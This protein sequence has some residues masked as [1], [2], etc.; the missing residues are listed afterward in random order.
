VVKTVQP[1]DPA[2]RA[3]LFDL[4]DTLCD[5][6]AARLARLRI[7]F[8]LDGEGRRRARPGID[9]DRMIEESIAIQPHG[10]DHFGDL[11]TKYG[12]EDPSEAEAA[13]RWYRTNRFHGLQLFP[14]A[15]EVLAAVGQI[16]Y[17]SGVIG[18]RPLG[19]VT[20]GPAEVQRAKAD[21]LGL[22]DLVDVIVISEEF[23]EAKP[24]PGI[25]REALWR[26]AATPEETVFVGDSPE[27]DIAGAASLGMRAVWV[28][29]SRVDW[30]HHSPAPAYQIG[31]LGELLTLLGVT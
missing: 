15:T 25:F 18:R 20:N 19:V 6:A 30:D 21:L 2:P 13:A 16:T 14:E 12:I 27:F 22:A 5:Y 23:G 24:G 17:P 28:N 31:S 8:Q 1:F 29:R 11:F 4:D 10:A 7:A 26:C 3:I 9:L